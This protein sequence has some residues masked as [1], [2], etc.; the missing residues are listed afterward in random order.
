MLTGNDWDE[1]LRE[2]IDSPNFKQLQQFLANEYAQHT[3]YPSM[4][5]IY[6]ALW[7]T[8]YV[9]LAGARFYEAVRPLAAGGPVHY[10]YDG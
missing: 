7:L 8:P 1:V 6:N 9:A 2:E 5:I 3:I 10:R 4:V